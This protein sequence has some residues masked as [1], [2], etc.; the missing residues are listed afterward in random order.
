MVFMNL[1]NNNLTNPKR[2]VLEVSVHL[3]LLIGEMDVELSSN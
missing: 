2:K 1:W 3:F